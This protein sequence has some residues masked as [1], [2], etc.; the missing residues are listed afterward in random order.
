MEE[1]FRLFEKEKTTSPWVDRGVNLLLVVV[2][3]LVV[4]GVLWIAFSPKTG[5]CEGEHAGAVED[6]DHPGSYKPIC[7]G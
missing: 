3:A 5:P 1:E 6:Q 4:G 2:A 7:M